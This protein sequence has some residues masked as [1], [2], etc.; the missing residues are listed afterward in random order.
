[1]FT[2]R[3]SQQGLYVL[4]FTS[5]FDSVTA[6]S[7]PIFISW[8]DFVTAVSVLFF[9]SWFDSVTADT[10]LLNRPQHFPYEP[11]DCPFMVFYSIDKI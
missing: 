5:W 2:V 10:V 1:M 7:V 4:F 3:N 6:G 8:F 11:P 9:L